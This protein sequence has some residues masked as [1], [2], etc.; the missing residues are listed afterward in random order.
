MVWLGSQS[1]T[2]YRK[3]GDVI[4][5]LWNCNFGDQWASINLL[6]CLSEMSGRTILTHSPLDKRKLHVEILESLSVPYKVGL[7][8]VTEKPDIDVVG[9]DVWATPFYNTKNHWNYKVAHKNVCYQFDGLSAGSDKNP[10]AQEEK[11][12]IRALEQSGFNPIKLGKNLSV[13][14]C[15]DAAVDSAFFVGVDSG[16]SHLC[17]SVGLPMFLLEY[18]LPVI[19]S[20]RG[21]QYTLCK[22]MDDFLQSKLPTWM[23]Y[24]RF[25]KHPDGDKSTI[26]KRGI[27]EKLPPKWWMPR[28]S[29]LL[30]I[31]KS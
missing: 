7:R 12:L 8:F 2:K 17:H 5:R 20:H 28:E 22:G 16:M 10:P 3:V 15:I 26:P 31:K 4:Y 23:D 18:K 25:I 29:P 13:K 11:L 6:L 30:T 27:R 9:F 24:L 19:T 14:E 21:K 1:G